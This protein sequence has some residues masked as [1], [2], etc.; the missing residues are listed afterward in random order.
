[1]TATMQSTMTEVVHRILSQVPMELPLLRDLHMCNEDALI[2]LMK[3]FATQNTQSK[4]PLV[5]GR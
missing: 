1:M 2:S 5:C 4:R 3:P